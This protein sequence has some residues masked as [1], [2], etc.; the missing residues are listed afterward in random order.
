MKK[1][2]P[3]AIC[4]AALSAQAQAQTNLTI[5]ATRP[6]TDISPDMWGIFFE[7]INFAADGG[8]YGE[9]VK[10]RSFEFPQQFMGWQTIG[11]VDL[12]ETDPAFKANPRYAIITKGESYRPAG[13]ENEGFR[14]I[15]LKQGETYDFSARVRNSSRKPLQLGV[16]LI[17]SIGRTYKT[18]TL[19][20]APAA[21]WQKIEATLTSELTDPKGRLRVLLLTPGTIDIDH[22]SLFPTDT[23]KG[24]K[25][26]LRR[27]LAQSLAD[28][29]PK[30]MRFPGGCI[31]EGTDLANRYQWKN[32]VGPVEER[33]LNINRW[34]YNFSNRMAPD[35]FQSAGLGFFEFFQ[36][37]EDI[38]A[39]PLPILSCGL[40][41]Q[42]ET[43]EEVPLDSLQPYIDDALDLIEF[44]NGP[45]TSRWGA[46]RAGMGHPEPF[47]LRY[48]GI[49]N[50]QWGEV[51]PERLELFLKQIRAK[52]PEIMVVGSAGP[53]PDGE[54][55]DY[56]WPE[57]RRLGA[58]LVDEHYYRSPDWFFNHADRYNSYPRKG[59]KVFAGE[60]ASHDYENRT[61]NTF[62]SALSEAAFMTGLERNADLV[63]MATYAP[64]FAHVEAN[65]WH[66]D[67][68]WFDN[69]DVMLTPNYY[70][71]QLFANNPGTRVLP[72]AASN[73][74][75][76]YTSATIDEP[77]GEVIVKIVNRSAEPKQVKLDLKAPKG[78]TYA[79][80]S[81]TYLQSDDLA[82][83]NAVG[84]PEKVYPRQRPVK[85]GAD[86]IIEVMPQSVN[87]YRLR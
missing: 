42:Y 34:N 55:F 85:V 59:P 78:K 63:R 58:D 68:I 29:S 17:N 73:G 43:G 41:C 87:V 28:L 44:A 1:L 60:Y 45:V 35:Y 37:S 67:L 40:A 76:I 30:V 36:L 69:A 74:P 27:D 5:D 39:T 25:G 61:A 57:M 84:Q 14:G 18:D 19:T 4:L 11:S 70:V 22:I 38:G 46:L 50:E 71:Q 54:Q 33:P 12:G 64:L 53:N 66:P 47:N 32:T 79:S 83:Q 6:G 80:G 13:L 56:L 82:A 77:T 20:V 2:Y 72:I 23:W 62:L 86:G 16:E 65:Q 26:G 49:G 81:H 7:D 10:N 24:R 9:L 31:V 52:H 3:I 15:S 8:L 48:I 21:G 75:E 51:Y